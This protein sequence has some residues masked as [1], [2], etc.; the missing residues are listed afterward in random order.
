MTIDAAEIARLRANLE[1]GFRL[2]KR[3]SI[4]LIDGLEKARPA[5]FGECEETI[6]KMA[7]DTLSGEHFVAFKSALDAIRA[8]KRNPAPAQP[9]S[10]LRARIT[11]M[12]GP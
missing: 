5:A 8:L 12:S 3:E 11:R 6:R 4:A 9:I 10:A 2:T 7:M 1:K